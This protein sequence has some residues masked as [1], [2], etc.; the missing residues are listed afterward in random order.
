[1]NTR[2]NHRRIILTLILALFIFACRPPPLFIEQELGRVCQVLQV[3]PARIE[4]PQVVW[5]DR[6]E[7]I[8]RLYNLKSPYTHAF[9]VWA[10]YEPTFNRI[11]I[12][13]QNYSPWLLHHELTHVV[14]TQI[15]A[16]GDQEPQADAV[17]D[18][19]N[20]K[21]CPYVVARSDRL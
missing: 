18:K 20:P 8:T 15:G 3:D 13:R 2:N 10:F 4:A 17:A 11:F 21:G 9:Y 14:L 12:S 6:S 1:M 19:L 7:Q 16:E 5:L